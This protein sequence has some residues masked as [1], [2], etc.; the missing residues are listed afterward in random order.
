[1]SLGMMLHCGAKEIDRDEIKHFPA[2]EAVETVRTGKRK[3]ISV[4]QP[5]DHEFL[6]RYTEKSL[7]HQGF[8]VVNRQFGIT[9][10]GARFFGLMEIEGKNLDGNGNDKGYSRLLGLRNSFDRSFAAGLAC[11]ARVL[12]CDNLSFS[13]E[14]TA[15]HRHT[16]NVLAKLPGMITT[17]I[18]KMS[19]AFQFQ[20]R[21]LE[22]YKSTTFDQYTLSDTVINLARESC[23]SGSHIVSVCDEFTKPTHEHETDSKVWN[24]FNAVTEVLKRV[25][26]EQMCTRTQKLHKTLDAHCGVKWVDVTAYDQH[27][28]EE[29]ALLERAEQPVGMEE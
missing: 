10:D 26:P 22:A 6:V 25:P 1:M 14:V 27:E 24:L 15:T 5:V 18:S 19:E 23:I 4:W 11:G 9:P 12:V 21:R 3:G 20:D 7:L 29:A 16:K 8:S 2:P 17:A 13:G 28:R